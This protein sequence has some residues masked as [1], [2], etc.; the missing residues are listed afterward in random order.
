MILVLLVAG[1][2]NVFPARDSGIMGASRPGVFWVGFPR[3]DC[4]GHRV[5]IRVRGRCLRVGVAGSTFRLLRN[6]ILRTSNM[7]D[8]PAGPLRSFAAFL[9]QER[10]CLTEKWMKAVFGDAGLG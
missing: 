2:Q 7:T 10:T 1:K 4:S 8:T 6:I 5:P 3:S 9:R